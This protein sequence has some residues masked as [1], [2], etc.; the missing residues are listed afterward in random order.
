MDCTASEESAP[1]NVTSKN[2]NTAPTVPPVELLL[3]EEADDQATAII[4]LGEQRV[5]QEAAGS[6]HLSL[7]V[8]PPSLKDGALTKD[9]T[10]VSSTFR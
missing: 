3:S 6:T 2:S 10:P 5:A 1:K 7:D 4:L 9:N 8:A